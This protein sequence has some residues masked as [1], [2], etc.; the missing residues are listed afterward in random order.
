ML[1]QINR[2]AF[3]IIGLGA[4][5]EGKGTTVDAFTRKFDSNLTVRFNGGNQA[6][7]NVVLEDGTHHTFSTFGAGTLVGAKTLLSE[8]VLIDP[9]SIALE[10]EHL[11]SIG[12]TN[13]LK[14]LYIHENCRVI[15]PFH[16]ALNRLREIQRGENKHGS[17]GKGIGEA[18]DFSLKYPNETLLA[19]DLRDKNLCKEKI[20]FFK[21]TCFDN[22]NFKKVSAH[23][24]AMNEILDIP[25][26]E[27]LVNEYKGLSD[28]FSIKTDEQTLNILA[29]SKTPI[30]EG[31]QGILIDENHGFHPYTTWSDTTPNNAI[32]FL[33]R[34]GFQ[35]IKK[36][37]VTR[38]FATRHGAGPFLTEDKYLSALFIDD[39][40]IEND[41]QDKFRWGYLDLNT[42]NYASKVCGRLD[43]LS[44]THLDKLQDRQNVCMAYKNEYGRV[45]QL[46]EHQFTDIR[47]QELFTKKIAKSGPIYLE[48]IAR[49]AILPLIEMATD[50]KVI[51]TSN[52]PRN[53]DKKWNETI[54]L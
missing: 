33:R 50:S 23:K 8:Q 13:K 36:I 4:G 25:S 45:F 12:F 9:F 48:N 7:H 38:T 6:A 37:G 21:K 28:M 41:W 30:F 22:L 19:K 53:I 18:V 5:D 10:N 2:S 3:I 46:K 15:T 34:A 35:D 14:Y 43:Y 31:A 44:V 29:G 26:I 1:N 49:D 40:N 32:H 54:Q 24:R 47:K 27:D 20:S 42:L 52:G 51:L 39:F 17:C 11:E 16:R